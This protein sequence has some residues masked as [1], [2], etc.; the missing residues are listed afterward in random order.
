MKKFDIR[1]TVINAFA[2]IP[3]KIIKMNNQSHWV[4]RDPEE[5]F[6]RL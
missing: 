1:T 3:A 2:E 5:N 4:N 6:Y